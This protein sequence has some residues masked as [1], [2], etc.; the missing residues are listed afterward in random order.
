MSNGFF[1]VGIWHP[2]YGVNVAGLMRSAHCFGAAYVFTVGRRYRRTSADTMNVQ[3]LVP[4]F[5]YLTLDDLQLPSGCP[6]VGVELADDAEA[7]PNFTHP[8]SAVYL[9][10]A[11]EH[12]LPRRILEQCHQVVQIPGL[13]CCLNVSVAGATVLYDRMLKEHQRKAAWGVTRKKGA[14]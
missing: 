2:K 3:G 11:E 1:A 10:G 8:R 6:L 5:H 7:L 12:G 13:R 14:A 9:L 4:C